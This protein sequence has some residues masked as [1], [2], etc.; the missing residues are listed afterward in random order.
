MYRLDHTAYQGSFPTGLGFYGG[1]TSDPITGQGG[2][3]GLAEFMMGAVPSYR[4][5]YTGL[6]W[7]PYQQ[8]RYWGF[9]FQDDWRITPNFTLNLGLRYDINGLFNT[10][11]GPVSNFCRECVNPLTGVP[12]TVTYKPAGTDIA[13]PNWNDLAPRFNFAWSPS[14]KWVFRGGYDV[15]YSN[16]INGVN[17]PGQA[18]SNAPGW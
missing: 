12:G 2:G 15:F 4:S 1:L 14:P 7:D 10:R 18:G 13:P 3:G 16:A 6:M 11:H 9:Y 5:S 8:F 17:A